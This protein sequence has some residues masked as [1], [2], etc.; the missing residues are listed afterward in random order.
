MTTST[1][2]IYAP[3]V[4]AGP[5]TKAQRDF[6]RAMAIWIVILTTFVT[7]RLRDAED[8]LKPGGIDTQ[9]KYQIL[10]WGF[11]G[12]IALR[13]ILCRRAD[14]KQLIQSPLMWF[15]IFVSTAVMSTAY[16]ISPPLTLFRSGQLVIAVLLV[17]SLREQI[18]RIYVFITVYIAAN[19]M[20]FLM[21]NTGLTFGLDWI[22]GPGNEYMFYN[23][24]TFLSWRFAT[25]LGHPSQ[26]SVVGAAGVVGLLARTRDWQWNRNFPWIAFLAV[27]VL[28]TISR[29][30]IAGM[31]AGSFLIFALRGKLL[32]FILAIGIVAPVTVMIPSVG[33]SLL[34]YV[35]RGQSAEEFKSLTGRSEI[36]ELGIK[37]A[38]ESLPL[39][40]G[41]VAGRAKAIVSKEVGGSIVHSH[42][43]FIESGVGMGAFGIIACAMVLISLFVA[44]FRVI[45][46]PPD[47]RGFSPGWEPF[48]ICI[49]LIAFCV[50][51]RG[52]AS[53]ADPFL[54]IFV[55]VLSML[56]QMNSA[57]ANRLVVRSDLPL[58]ESAG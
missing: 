23:R 56:T 19:W 27:T 48:A 53:P 25:P 13:C 18:D 52:F 54:C 34:Y 37:R 57:E 1:S 29:T 36:Y 30:A 45:K 17:V 24:D 11:L 28:L 2:E 7:V 6:R 39:G 47:D 32:P 15:A 38:A 12:L 26:I 22:R 51:D 8:L 21:A 40:E 3:A 50:L 33:E 35:M 4:S 49:P 55:T 44:L 14:L 43:L 10:V 5:V 58:P 42:N 9:A 20:F 31:L 41:F 16:S 46:I